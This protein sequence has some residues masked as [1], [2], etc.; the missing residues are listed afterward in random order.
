VWAGY[1]VPRHIWH[2][3]QDSM[4]ALLHRNGLTLIDIKPMKLDSFYVSL[5]SEQYKNPEQLKII[6]A[7]KAFMEGITSNIQARKNKEYSSLIYIARP[8]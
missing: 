6:T 1:D 7:L 4:H 5:L 2:F 8:E 3:T